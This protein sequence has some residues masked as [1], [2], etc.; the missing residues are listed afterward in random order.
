MGKF[1]YEDLEMASVAFDFAARLVQVEPDEDWIARCLDDRLFDGA[2]FGESDEAVAKGLSLMRNWCEGA[3]DD[4]PNAIALLRR[5]WLRLFIGLGTPE[6]SINES[7]YTEPNSTMFGR[8]TLEVRDAY[9][10]WGLESE[11]KASEPDDA[12]GIMLAFCAHLMRAS[13]RAHEVGDGEASE[14]ALEAFEQFLAKH[15]LPWA[16]AWRFLVNQHAKTDYYRGVGEL[17]FGLERACAER[18]D[19]AFNEEKGSF[20]YARA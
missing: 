8:T 13:V 16:S 15:M 19:I 12:L 7:F 10:A 4:M 2:P 3:K 20:S 5:E 14:K 1:S 11:R 17:V 18:F 6:A 9:R